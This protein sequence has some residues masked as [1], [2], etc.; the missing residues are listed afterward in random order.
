MCWGCFVCLVMLSDEKLATRRQGAVA[1]T[2][3]GARA[4]VGY[5][6]HARPGSDKIQGQPSGCLHFKL[7]IT[8]IL[9]MCFMD[10]ISRSR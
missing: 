3:G 6:N 2:I 9:T 10:E 8:R 1:Q 7:D 4:T 5:E